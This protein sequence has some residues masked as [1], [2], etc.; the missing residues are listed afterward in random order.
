MSEC[1]DGACSID[2]SK[3]NGKLS[4]PEQ[5]EARRIKAMLAHERLKREN[6]L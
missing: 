6:G 2:L 3:G 4:D 1:N 5:V